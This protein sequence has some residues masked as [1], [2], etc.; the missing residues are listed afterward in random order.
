[1]VRGLDYGMESIFLSRPERSWIYFRTQ[2]SMMV[3]RAGQFSFNRRKVLPR[4][5]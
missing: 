4:K 2:W 3:V 5:F 1:M